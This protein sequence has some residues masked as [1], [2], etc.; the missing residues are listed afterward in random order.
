MAEPSTT[1]DAPEP[2]PGNGPQA[3][4]E[5]AAMA[6]EAEGVS[7]EGE[8]VTTEEQSSFPDGEA[9]TEKMPKVAIPSSKIVP[10]E[11]ASSPEKIVSKEEQ[12]AASSEE[13][14]PTVATQYPSEEIVP[15]ATVSS[16]EEIAPT[17]AASSSKETLP[18][19]TASSSQEIA[20]SEEPATP[21]PKEE[22]PEILRV[23]TQSLS[24]LYRVLLGLAS[25]V[26]GITSITIQLL[27]LPSQIA[28]LDP[29]HPASSL[30][31]VAIAGGLAAFVAAPLA[32]AFSDRTTARF[33]RRRPW[34]LVGLIGGV[35]SLLVMA[36]STSVLMLLTG[37]VLAQLFFGIVYTMLTAVI[38]DQVPLRQ[39]A[40]V[41]AAVGI[42]P[43]VGSAV[44]LL[45]VTML[46]LGMRQQ[47]FWIA[48]SAFVIVALFLLVFRERPLPR[49]AMPP[50]R[51]KAFAASFWH[52]PKL[53]PN[54]TLVWFSRSFLFLGY[55][56][57]TFYLLS[58]L[59][60]VLHLTN[61]DATLR[62]AILQVLS[63]GTLIVFAFLGGWLADR[64]QRLKLFASLGAVM[65]AGAIFVVAF[66][67]LWQYILLA[68]ALFGLG[69]GLYL[70]VNLALT[71]RVL[72]QARDHGKDL[73]IM[74][75]TLYLALIVTP[76]LAGVVLNFSGSYT[77]LFSLA[78]VT[79]LIAGGLLAP[80][81]N[82]R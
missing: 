36:F 22:L 1:A 80:I 13:I 55:T 9:P 52:N 56:F 58:Y 53:H 82:V 67:P 41:T 73:G 18:I 72:P 38:P 2:T 19:V 8:E 68:S 57:F 15:T 35:A 44:G 51:F 34:M 29:A 11:E 21:S 46:P 32:G 26:S 50:F 62:V 61:A 27:L 25:V 40:T 76:P 70:A 16:S 63:T 65:M 3:E 78:A 47:Y 59:V 79:S 5:V 74:N 49:G 37:E 33:G 48:G 60:N 6:N 31:L 20:S 4:P 66:V 7:S 54:F 81:S 30:S 12:E 69:C 71:I 23:P 24:T 43:V 17:I 14:L 77:M 28:A 39:R 75:I 64:L 45:V 42:A 10:I